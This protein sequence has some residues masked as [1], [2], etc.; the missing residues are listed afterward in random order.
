MCAMLCVLRVEQRKHLLQCPAWLL[1]WHRPA[2]PL[3]P[4]TDPTIAI[5]NTSGS[6]PSA[7][8][9]PPV[10]NPAERWLRAQNEFLA[11]RALPP[12]WS[13]PSSM[14][15][16]SLRGRGRAGRNKGGG[17]VSGGDVG[18]GAGH[19]G[20]DSGGLA[21]R[22]PVALRL[23]ATGATGA[24][25]ATPPTPQTPPSSLPTTLSTPTL[26]TT[27]SECL[28]ATGDPELDAYLA[29]G[30]LR[31]GINEIYGESATGKTQFCLHL[32]MACLTQW[33]PRFGSYAGI[34]CR[35]MVVRSLLI[36]S[37][38]CTVSLYCPQLRTLSYALPLTLPTIT[39]S[40][41]VVYLATEDRFPA[42]R[43][44]EMIEHW[45][46]GDG[47]GGVS[48]P[49]VPFQDNLYVYH[50]F[51]ME[52]QQHTI[53][54]QLP[55]FLRRNPH[56][57]L[58][59]VDSIAANFRYGCSGE[60]GDGG[61]GNE[62]REEHTARPGLYLLSSDSSSTKSKSKSK[63]GVGV[64]TEEEESSSMS[65]PMSKEKESFAKRMDRIRAVQTL[66][67]QL[68]RISDRF[69]V[70]VLCVNQITGVLDDNDDQQRR[71]GQGGGSGHHGEQTLVSAASLGQ[72]WARMVN[73]RLYL[74]RKED[75]T[76]AP[77]SMSSM[78]S[79]SPTPLSPTPLQE[80]HP[81]QRRQMSVVFA[82]HCRR[83]DPALGRYPLAYSV[84]A[85]GISCWCSGM[86]G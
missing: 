84:T 74:E 13:D 31:N 30:F 10:D 33:L 81:Q 78:S 12:S 20:G 26:T 58:L 16:S 59:I 53:R 17:G 3:P 5:A 82:P 8:G 42:A 34:V 50:L 11:P 9:G 4:A 51:D 69:G 19:S 47:D 64:V 45:Q 32:A 46:T 83:T 85:R 67:R 62:G 7:I 36:T 41:G 75:G 43:L 79:M 72:S 57:R 60:G 63:S 52:D 54:Y 77:S 56:V 38:H 76:R 55:E 29:G 28:L 61:D 37:L 35:G 22:F 18:G 21:H 70:A 40:L 27:P 1:P 65:S 2:L 39:A 49:N 15:M 6:A 14:A 25:A 73:M 44:Q 24:T 23:A 71:P 66:G 48:Y 86:E 68:K 80:Q